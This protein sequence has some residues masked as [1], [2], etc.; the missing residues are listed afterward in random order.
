V[1]DLLTAEVLRNRST[2]LARPSDGVVEPE[3]V[4]PVSA[5]S[6]IREISSSPAGSR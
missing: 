1:A 3:L 5:V 4:P 2:S 6:M